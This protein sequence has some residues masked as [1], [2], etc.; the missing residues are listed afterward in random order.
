L[1][2]RGADA[3]VRDGINMIPVNGTFGEAVSLMWD[4]LK[5]FSETVVGAIRGR[6]PVFLGATTLNT[7]DTIERRRY[8]RE[9]GADG[10]FLGRPM[11]CQMSQ[12]M[13]VQYYRD[14]AEA[15]PKCR[16]RPWKTPGNVA[17]AGNSYEKSIPV[18]GT[19]LL[20]DHYYLERLRWKLEL[21]KKPMKGGCKREIRLLLR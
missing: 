10:L 3:L 20:S 15:L 7:R 12:E 17:A 13:T 14:R 9:I 1:Q 8:F 21:S 11:W 16:I 6:I 2:G 4:E 19:R 5:K 18:R